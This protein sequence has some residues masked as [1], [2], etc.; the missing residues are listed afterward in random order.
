MG[1]NTVT[2]QQEISDERISDLLCTWYESGFSNFW[3]ESVK[4]SHKPA[5]LGAE[6]TFDLPLKGGWLTI[7]TGDGPPVV[8]NREAITKGLQVFA[9]KYPHLYSE[10]INENDDANTADVFV[11]CC[12]FGEEV[13]A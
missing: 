2:V 12:L 6:Y 3:I 10:F 1:S 13:Y 9:D 11:Q 8:L 7:E 4:R 5:D